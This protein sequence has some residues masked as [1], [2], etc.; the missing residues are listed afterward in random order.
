MK[1]LGRAAVV[2]LIF[3]GL[4]ASSASADEKIA[5]GVYSYENVPIEEGQSDL[6]R[7]SDARANLF[8]ELADRLES[9]DA[10]NYLEESQDR[11]K[12]LGAPAALGVFQDRF[13]E[14]VD[15]LTTSPSEIPN[16]S[17]VLRYRNRYSALVDPPGPK[18]S[19]LFVSNLPLL[20]DQNDPIDLSLRSGAQKLRPETPLVELAI[21][22]DPAGEIE[23]PA[24]GLS[25]GIEDTRPNAVDGTVVN[26]SAKPNSKELSF[27]PNAQKDTD[28]AVVPTVTGFEVFTQ[29]RSP[30]SPE[31]FA[32]EVDIPDGGSLASHGA[33]AVIVD[34]TGKALMDVLPP[35]AV[36]AQGRDVPVEMTVSEQSIVLDVPH[37]E[38]EE[39]AYP[40]LV[41]PV[42]DDR[43]W[44]NQEQTDFL[45]WSWAQFGS[46][47]YT[48]TFEC[49]PG[50]V[51]NESCGGV[52]NGMGL[53]VN[54]RPSYSF[55]AGSNA[56]FLWTP[57]G[58]DSYITK[59]VLSSW[60]FRKG[61]DTSNDP[62]AFFG[63]ATGYLWNQFVEVTTGSG[64]NNMQLTGGVGARQLAVGMEAD[65]AKTLPSGW[66]NFR[67]A[68]LAA[69][70]IWLDDQNPPATPTPNLSQV[71]TGWVKSMPAGF[72]IG[73]TASD[74]GLG[75]KSVTALSALDGPG[76][77]WYNDDKWQSSCDG[78]WEK[79]CQNSVTGTITFHPDAVQQGITPVNILATDAL[80]KS[81][82]GASNFNIKVDRRAP[83]LELSDQLADATNS[84]V[85]QDDA[86]E[87]KELLTRT[88]YRLDIKGDDT[89]S[90]KD[91]SGI[92]RIEIARNSVP[93][94]LTTM[95]TVHTKNFTCSP[96][97]Q[98]IENYS[99]DLELEGL[100]PGEYLLTVKVFDKAGNST[101]RLITF[102]Y[103]PG[104]GLKDE[105]VFQDI[106]LPDESVISVNVANGNLVYRKTDLKEEGADVD[107]EIER[108]YNS[109]L[110]DSQSGEWGN[111]W[112]LGDNPSLDVRAIAGPED[113]ATLDS[114]DGAV[115]TEVALPDTPGDEIFDAEAQVVAER[116]SDGY[117]LSEY[118]SDDTFQFATDGTHKATE[119][120]NGS[121][122]EYEHDSNGLI[123]EISTTNAYD[124]DADIAAEVESDNGLVETVDTG[125]QT[126][127]LTHDVS[128]DLTAVES[129]DGLTEYAYGQ[130]SLLERIDLADGSFV[131][132]QYD[133]ERRVTQVKLKE[134]SQTAK[135]WTFAYSTPVIISGSTTV[136]EPG[137]RTTQFLI[138]PAG[139]VIRSQSSLASMNFDATGSLPAARG[140]TL[141]DPGEYNVVIT[142]TGNEITKTA[143]IVDGNVTDV[144]ECDPTC[145][146][147]ENE[148]KVDRAN[149]PPGLI[150]VV[151]S[152]ERSNGESRAEYVTVNVPTT[153]PPG[154]EWLP[155][156][157]GDALAFRTE[158]GLSTDYPTVNAMQ[159]DPSY[160]YNKW[161]LPLSVPEIAELQYRENYIA[162]SETLLENYS[163]ANPSIFAGS[164]VESTTGIVRVGITS[165]AVDEIEE[166]RGQFSAPGRLQLFAVAP[167]ASLA[168]LV[169]L[170][171]EVLDDIDASSVP[172]W[173]GLVT[174]S[175][176]EER[177]SVL[178]VVENASAAVTNY[179]NTRYGSHIEV[180]EDDV[181][182]T[183]GWDPIFTS[184]L[185]AGTGFGWG[186]A[187]PYECTLG[188][189]VKAI[190]FIN[191]KFEA[192]KY[193]LS[194]GHCPG[195]DYDLITINLPSASLN[196]PSA[197]HTI[198]YVASNEFQG[199]WWPDFK[200]IKL[201]DP[202]QTPCTI[203]TGVNGAVQLRVMGERS[204]S[205]LTRRL[206][207]RLAGMSS[208]TESGRL[209][210]LINRDF[211]FDR[212][213]MGVSTVNTE[214]GD[215]GGPVYAKRKGKWGPV[216]A[217][218]IQHAGLGEVSPGSRKFKNSIFTPIGS[219]RKIMMNSTGANTCE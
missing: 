49:P 45:G 2:L 175:V 174:A 70:G 169:G 39:F 132:I 62:H 77:G 185:R 12:D 25:V 23:L 91:V 116:L 11:F 202:S 81:T 35:F 18:K 121:I 57:P 144:Q 179:L 115:S 54:A 36:D 8:A 150:T 138:G 163:T 180:E 97:C 209:R 134:S 72:P 183:A 165:G 88:N 79:R 43:D 143:V 164:F 52:G 111:K 41:D 80:G 211:I 157:I 189:G 46:T 136:V 66:Q 214:P 103:N 4:G 85:D 172:G 92:S 63:I 152:A 196:V 161:G 126:V 22:K 182:M 58:N 108:F 146:S 15:G 112:T 114:A 32:Y 42:F 9:T 168:T 181:Q 27:Y 75:I 89:N 184:P 107:L 48:G 59:A 219:I 78:T 68:R 73:F 69:F 171:E 133:S 200:N 61:S 64:G 74:N 149:L 207:L 34:S 156:A 82:A 93:G 51:S 50:I 24:S 212:I 6:F 130:A 71:P 67:Y 176:E 14:M 125:S 101:W 154:E 118:A 100:A 170:E 160:W 31:S 198:G 148:W 141:H 173:V 47:N 140:R 38:T 40:I 123:E 217:V 216:T 94:D 135:I 159:N 210:T 191:N 199:K 215:S 28:V 90:N 128:E 56:R 65:I 137:G 83:D 105:Y 102:N 110:Q 142:A 201:T 3:V 155:P 44:W 13:G 206:P 158:N 95:S 19:V 60:R 205:A 208:G 98:K 178:A 122:T 37:K 1:R 76:G 16:Q 192:V 20:N 84:S 29:V 26:A 187:K 197:S 99:W 194:A 147:V 139:L 109:Q 106:E 151:A 213:P 177:N 166:L 195:D 190:V 113:T 86:D 218:G 33:G 193:T 127:E 55:A 87:E 30:E 131:E 17:N 162:E 119:T 117:A 145:P 129:E 167:T 153:P 188:F 124:P 120:I 186:A 21:P 96:N 7:L 104:T 203:R 204:N 5:P 10:L 53:Y